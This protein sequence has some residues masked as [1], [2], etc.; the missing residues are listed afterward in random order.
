[1][2]TILGAL[3]CAYFLYANPLRRV[4]ERN[5][6]RD[7]A[8]E[9]SVWGSVY[10]STIG[11]VWPDSSRLMRSSSAP[12]TGPDSR[13]SCSHKAGQLLSVEAGARDSA[14]EMALRARRSEV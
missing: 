14:L 2:T 5:M 1:M 9:R 10:D 12:T 6:E 7:T 3:N 8:A 13:K 4:A 11:S